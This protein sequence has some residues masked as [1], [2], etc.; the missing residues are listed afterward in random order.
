MDASRA[1]TGMLEVF[2]T[3]Q[4]AA[5]AAAAQQAS[6]DIYYMYT[7]LSEAAVQRV[8]RCIPQYVI[9]MQ[10]LA[11]VHADSSCHKSTIS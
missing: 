1:A 4:A 7:L 6:V 5:A 8:L 9:P 11:P 10:L 2:A 3:W